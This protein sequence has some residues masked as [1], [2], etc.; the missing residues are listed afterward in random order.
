MDDWTVVL[1][2]WLADKPPPTPCR[3]AFPRRIGFNCNRLVG[4]AISP[5]VVRSLHVLGTL[6]ALAHVYRQPRR[7]QTAFLGGLMPQ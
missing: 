5:S 3:I 6:L 2:T 4:F 1:I 7:E